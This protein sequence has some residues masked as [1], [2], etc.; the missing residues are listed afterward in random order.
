MQ[1]SE[2]VGC[3]PGV[4]ERWEVGGGGGWGDTGAAS[5]VATGAI[6]I[7]EL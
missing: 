6:P 4:W 1:K 3:L 7:P 2:P 5:C